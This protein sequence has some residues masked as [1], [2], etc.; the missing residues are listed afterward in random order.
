MPLSTVFAHGKLSGN[1]GEKSGK[2]RPNKKAGGKGAA[3]RTPSAGEKPG[4]P[5]LEGGRDPRRTDGGE[6]SANIRSPAL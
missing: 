5:P 6:N 4:P 1:A 2:R 3:C